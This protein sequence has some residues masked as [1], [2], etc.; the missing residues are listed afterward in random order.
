VP[1]GAQGPA[2]ALDER[3][4]RRTFTAGREGGRMN[5]IVSHVPVHRNTAYTFRS[6][7]FNHYYF[8]ASSHRRSRGI[9]TIILG[10]ARRP[11]AGHAVGIQPGGLCRIVRARTRFPTNSTAR[12]GQ[13]NRPFRSKSLHNDIST[14]YV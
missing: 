7:F 13:H 5:F 10:A 8:P 6:L 1:E 14:M 2:Q 4:G 12:A 11:D 9:T 3:P